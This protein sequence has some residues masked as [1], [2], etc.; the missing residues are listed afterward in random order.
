MASVLGMDANNTR[1]DVFRYLQKK[2]Y[3]AAEILQCQERAA[4]TPMAAAFWNDMRA[5]GIFISP[6]GVDDA[7]MRYFHW[8]YESAF[9][10]TST[11][12]FAKDPS[13]DG[14]AEAIKSGYSVATE[15][16]EDGP[17]HIVGSYRLTKYTLFLLE[18]YFPRHDELCFE[19]GCRM[20][21]CYLGD[22]K[23]REVLELINGRI[24][25]YQKKFFGR[26]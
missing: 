19:E 9:N 21:D 6:V 8:S 12:I 14:F 2:R 25:D 10:W 24:A 15:S 5:D 22:E 1:D 13:F 23:S 16:Y 18:Q 17:E 11:M 7:H 20:R 3:D 4:L 26:E